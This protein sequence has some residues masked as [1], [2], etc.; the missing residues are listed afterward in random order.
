VTGR[1]GRIVV[2][3]GAPRS[4]KSSIVAALQAREDAVWI[5][6]GVDIHNASMLPPRLRP[7]IGVRPG[8]ER[9]DLEPLLPRLY[10]GLYE[11]IAAQS[12]LGLDVVA[13]LGHH[14]A[15]SQPLGILP[16]CARRLKGLPALFV[17]IHC[18]LDAILARRRQQVAGR[19]TLY[20][21]T[22]EGEPPPA[23]VL[24]WQEA[25]HAHGLYDLTID[26]STMTPDEAAT[27]ILA[28][29]AKGLPRP[30]AF[31]QLAQRG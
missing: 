23:P 21:S 5:N 27:V 16:D 26:T 14:D 13:D 4:G 12:R 22:A 2:L 29:F 3:N 20:A 25:V 17:G 30:S 9:P 11:A 19:E 31:E 28:A 1:T 7:G 10:A 18:P 15:Y 6:L 24:L 8:G